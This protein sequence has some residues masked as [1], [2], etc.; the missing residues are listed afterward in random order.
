[1]MA[2]S[3]GASNAWTDSTFTEIA[4]QASNTNPQLRVAYKVAGSSEPSSYSF[5]IGE[6]RT[7][8]G[9]ILTYRYAAY[10][11][12]AGSFTT[13]ANPL[14]LTSISP[15]ESQSILIAA[16]AR[17]SNNITLGTPTGMAARVTD[18]DATSPSYIVCDQTVA[19]GPTGTRSM[20]TGSTNN[21]AGIMLSIKPTRSLS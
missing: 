8:S 7:L 16:G 6:S 18:N 11:T 19:K 17:G 4:D 2:A 9:C 5:T 12:I 14:V 15:S 21:V 20:S 10:D 13:G 3:S 1:V